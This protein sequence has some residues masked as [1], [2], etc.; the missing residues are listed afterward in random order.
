MRKIAKW[1]NPF[2]TGKTQVGANNFLT[3]QEAVY[4]VNIRLKAEVDESSFIYNPIFSLHTFGKT[5]I[6]P[7]NASNVV[8]LK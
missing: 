2:Y 8:R 5:C 4:F 7:E 6:T 3:V 1:N